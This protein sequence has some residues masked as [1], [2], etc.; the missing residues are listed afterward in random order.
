MGWNGKLKIL[1][2]GLESQRMP[3]LIGMLGGNQIKNPLPMD[4]IEQRCDAFV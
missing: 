1:L 2:N 3:F 4:G